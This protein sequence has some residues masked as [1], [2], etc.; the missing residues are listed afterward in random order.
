[1]LSPPF[2]S[3]LQSPVV[4]RVSGVSEAIQ[5][6]PSGSAA[7]PDRVTPQILKDLISQRG[8]AS[9]PFLSSLTSFINI[10]LAGK[11]PV[12]IRPF[13]FGAN[14]FALSKKT[15]GVRP[16]RVIRRPSTRLWH[17]SRSRGCSPCHANDH[18]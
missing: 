12:L 15:G 17:A 13:V 16:N 6:F 8:E 7:G 5:S 4:C 14:L 3:L 2:Q 1:M 18:T 10:V 11:V 9:H